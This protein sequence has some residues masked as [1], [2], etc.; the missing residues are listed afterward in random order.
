M[1]KN[2]RGN[3]DGKNGSNNSYTIPGRGI[4]PRKKLVKEVDGGKHQNH[5]IVEI[6]G[7]EYV[8]SN[9]D[10]TPNNNVD[11]EGTGTL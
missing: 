9:P 8:R 3:K 6:D 1:A 5:H 10:K 7:K 2:I 11:K 4:V